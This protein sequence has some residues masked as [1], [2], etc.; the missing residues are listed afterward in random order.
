[1]RMIQRM[2]TSTSFRPYNG[3]G[4]SPV[5]HTL[6]SFRATRARGPSQPSFVSEERDHPDDRPDHEAD[7][8]P[9]GRVRVLAGEEDVH[10]EDPRDQ[11]QRQDDD[12]EDR[13]DAK[14]V[15][16]A[17][18]DQLLVRALERLDHFLVVVEQIPDAL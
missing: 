7:D 8:D 16:L 6:V 2:L 18:R 9:E 3:E 5:T 12:A 13:E 17:V 10:A 11:S 1:M 15:V 4:R 14:D